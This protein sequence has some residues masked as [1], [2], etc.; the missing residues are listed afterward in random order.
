LESKI[1]K[2]IHKSSELSGKISIGTKQ[3]FYEIM[4]NM[5][6]YYSNLIEGNPTHPLDIEKAL[7]GEYFQD[8]KKR[9]KVEQNTA[10]IKTQESIK[11]RVLQEADL[12]ITSKDFIC[13]IHKELYQ[14]LDEEFRYINFQGE[15]IKIIPGELRKREVK[16]G[17]HNAPLFE[18]LNNFLE[19]FNQK[20]SPKNLSIEKKLLA[21]AASHHRLVFIHPFLDGN[22][23]VARLFSYAYALKIGIA[24][25]GI[26]SISRGLART[27]KEYYMNLSYADQERQ[28][29][30][31]GRG[32]LTEKG[33]Y[34]FCN[35][36]FNITLDQLSFM[37]NLLNLEKF[38]IHLKEILKTKSLSEIHQKRA[39]IILKEIYKK[40]ELKR[41]DLY[42]LFDVKPR[43]VRDTLLKL[44]N[45]KLIIS[46]THKSPLK[47]NFKVEDTINL[48]P[49]LIPRYLENN[50]KT[51]IKE[52]AQKKFSVKKTE[53]NFKK[54][55]EIFID[56]KT[57]IIANRELVKQLPL[58]KQE[59]VIEAIN[60][61]LK[62]KADYEF[63]LKIIESSLK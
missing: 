61:V 30:L 7:N 15:K 25:D 56:K 52:E 16:V 63:I 58:K 24:S 40:G 6:G 28:G 17:M 43:T 59:E 49:D 2:I 36:F 31:D 32:N 35:Y 21:F 48:F 39:F 5:N 38:E 11:K 34:E 57:E 26:W 46:D 50:M 12:N 20:Y 8:E 33:L 41:K 3:S 10:H 53:E 14:N 54:Y 23:R 22:G 45:L 55:E 19:F 13:W 37:D 62:I 9:E 29:D 18:S 60:G 27:R 42:N 47:L 1:I 51:E 4:K 44:N